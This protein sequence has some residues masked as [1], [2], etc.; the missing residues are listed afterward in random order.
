[1]EEL[2]HASGWF[3]SLSSGLSR[4]WCTLGNQLYRHWDEKRYLKLL[5]SNKSTR[6]W[7]FLSPSGEKHLCS[8]FGAMRSSEVIRI[9]RLASSPIFIV[10][11]FALVVVIHF[12]RR[13]KAFLFW[14][15]LWRFHL[16]HSR[17][18]LQFV[19]LNKIHCL[20]DNQTATWG[21][22]MG[23]VSCVWNHTFTCLAKNHKTPLA[24][25]IQTI[26]AKLK[27]SVL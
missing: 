21:K 3:S 17:W 5:S 26:L 25:N 24:S 8:V 13:V 15:S 16:I 10:E 9:P 2:T 20:Q 11:M 23:R 7:V 1:M 22:A 27:K 6:D 14:I 18:W 12:W 4:P 19:N